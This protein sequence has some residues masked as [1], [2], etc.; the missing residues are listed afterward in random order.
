MISLLWIHP[1]LLIPTKGE[2]AMCMQKLSVTGSGGDGDGLRDTGNTGGGGDGVWTKKGPRTVEQRAQRRAS[3][4]QALAYAYQVIKG[5]PS[6]GIAHDAAVL[7]L[8][9]LKAWE[10]DH[11]PQP[12]DPLLLPEHLRT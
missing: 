5:V 11:A 12:L 3:E 10:R 9:A 1:Q 8:E 4:L 7:T 6:A 2:Q